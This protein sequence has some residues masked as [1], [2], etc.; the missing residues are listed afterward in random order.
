MTEAR[1][2]FLILTVNVLGFVGAFLFFAA[3][4]R[5]LRDILRAWTEDE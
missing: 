4:L 3:M 1:L 5:V 2:L